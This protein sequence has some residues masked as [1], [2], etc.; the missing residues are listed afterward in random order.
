MLWRCVSPSVFMRNSVRVV[1]DLIQSWYFILG[2]SLAPL[3]LDVICWIN[4]LYIIPNLTLSFRAFLSCSLIH[5]RYAFLGR[6]LLIQIGRVVVVLL[7][8]RC[9]S[10]SRILLFGYQ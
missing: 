3:C 1:G 10:V 6:R 2:M 4:P 5:L 8:L 9:I 7:H